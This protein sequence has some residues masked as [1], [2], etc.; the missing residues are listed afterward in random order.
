MPRYYFHLDECGDGT[1]DEEGREVADD[2]GARAYAIDMARSI[3][4]AEIDEGKLCM[5]CA[6]KIADADGAPVMTL[7][8][9]EAIALT[10]V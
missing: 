1:R 8:F 5:R 3:M 2:A 7:Q 4:K 9:S 6:I 10:G